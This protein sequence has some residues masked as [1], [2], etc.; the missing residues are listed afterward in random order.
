MFG[1]RDF[2]GVFDINGRLISDEFERGNEVA[3]HAGPEHQRSET[4]NAA[5]DAPS[6]RKS[7]SKE[8]DDDDATQVAPTTPFS[9]LESPRT[10][11]E[12]KK[13]EELHRTTQDGRPHTSNGDVTLEPGPENSWN[14]S[15]L[16]YDEFDADYGRRRDEDGGQLSY[17]DEYNA[18]EGI[19][20]DVPENNEQSSAYREGPPVENKKATSVPR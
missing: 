17:D 20:G 10:I 1:L 6:T 14:Q 13:L 5:E 16:S 7:E 18:R 2:E 15:L 4:S 12:K 3:E 19:D 11:V 9:Y 8:E